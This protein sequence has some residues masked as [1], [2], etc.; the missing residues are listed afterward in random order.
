LNVGT[1]LRAAGV[2]TD[3][4]VEA[5]DG[6]YRVT[7]G[8]R[9]YEVRVLARA[10]GRLDLAIGDRRVHA[11]VAVSADKAYVHAAGGTFLVEPATAA[12]RARHALA[13]HEGDVEATMPGQVRAVLVEEGQAV[14]RNDPLVI[15]EAMKMELRLRAP[16]EGRVRRLC[17]RVGDV[18][19]RG[20]ILVELE[21]PTAAE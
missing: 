3:V 14:A 17:C 15:L 13:A 8:E 1:R 20:Q 16:R 6:T 4:A 9:H 19:E 21:A 7:I 12:T 18:V 10:G 2:E 11:V 5:R